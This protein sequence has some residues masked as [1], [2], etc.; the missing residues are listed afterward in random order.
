MTDHN[1]PLFIQEM[2]VCSRVRHPHVVAICGVTAIQ[3]AAPRIILELL[4]GSLADALGSAQS[5]GQYLTFREQIDISVDCL[6]G[7]SHLHDLQPDALLH[8]DIRPT[9]IL[10][11]GMM[12]AKIGDLGAAHFLGVSLS[13]GPVSLDYL[14]PERL[15][16]RTGSHPHNTPAA[17]IYCLGVTLAE[18]FTGALADCNSRHRHFRKIEY[19][20]LRDLCLRM[21]HDDPEQRPT[22]RHVLAGLQALRSHDDYK[23][24]SPKRL[25]KGKRFGDRVILTNQPW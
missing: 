6:L 13:I 7:I 20:K 5:C 11:T 16:S 18:I 24:C 22:A 23:S 3:D 4:E 14:A 10:L 12:T 25:V 2:S 9:N 15:P 1:R 8:G 19:D 17:D 21:T